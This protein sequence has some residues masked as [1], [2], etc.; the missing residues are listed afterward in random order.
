MSV[1]ASAPLDV[2]D[3]YRTCEFA[4]LGK[5]GT[6]AAWPTAVKRRPD[7]TL[8]L[9]TSLAF[10][11]KAFNI[12]RDGRVAL[13]FSDPTGS[14]LDPAPQIAVSG[15]AAHGKLYY[16]VTGTNKTLWRRTS[17]A[18]PGARQ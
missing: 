3:A 17:T 15:R 10:A 5:D 6:P 13:L 8:L 16:A 4:T 11:Q 9:T 14:G 2:L 12:R 1:L 18:V 7:G